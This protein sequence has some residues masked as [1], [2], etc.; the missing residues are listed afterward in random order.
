M[1]AFTPDLMFEQLVQNYSL[2]KQIYGES[3]IRLISGYEPDYVKKNIGI[4]EF[5]KE[6]KEK[7]TE[8]N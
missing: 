8:E 2:A 6:L 7:N 5:K 4:P 3:I 1:S